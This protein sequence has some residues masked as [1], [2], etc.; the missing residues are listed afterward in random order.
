MKKLILLSFA[1]GAT[2]SAFA[3]PDMAFTGVGKGIGVQWTLDSGN[4]Y[5]SSFAGEIGLQLTTSTGT[6]NFYGYCVDISV[7]IPDNNPHG[8]QILDTNSLSPNGPGIGYR[9]NTFAPGIRA[10]GSD[11]EAAA[12]QIAFW[13]LL[14]ETGGTYDITAGNY[15]ARKQDGSPL[16]AE[17]VTKAQQYLA[18][19]GSSVAPYY[20]SDLGP[21]GPLSQ[22]FVAPVPEPTTIAALGIGLAALL[23]KRGRK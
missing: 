22:S 21:N 8:V 18:A 16:E 19:A 7:F 11:N 12:L 2:A 23:R 1:I 20:K 14:Y 15:R 3:L 9:V 4:N 10:T 5:T 6:T 17:V 13:E